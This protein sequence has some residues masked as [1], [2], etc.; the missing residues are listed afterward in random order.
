VS[1]LLLDVAATK[2]VPFEKAKKKFVEPSQPEQ[3]AL[4]GRLP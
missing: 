2:G 3:P 1:K 4:A